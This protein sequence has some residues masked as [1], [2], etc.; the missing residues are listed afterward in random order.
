MPNVASIIKSHN[1][2]I[3]SKKEDQQESG[4]PSNCRKKDSCPL[5]G[6]CQTSGV[7]YSAEVKA[8]NEDNTKLYIGLTE[9][10]FKTR[11]YIHQQSFRKE[12][13]K[14]STEL[15]RYVWKIKKMKKEPIITWSIAAKAPNDATYA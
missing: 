4:K 5:Q 12:N 9:L 3:S 2:K 8:A 7:I 13:Y 6:K 1:K 15:S 14:N 11:Y 10:P